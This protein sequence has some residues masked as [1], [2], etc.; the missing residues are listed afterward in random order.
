MFLFVGSLS[1]AISVAIF[2]LLV[3]VM[4]ALPADATAGPVCRAGGVAAR[5]VTAPV[6]F[7]GKRTRARR[8][9]RHT[10][11]GVFGGFFRSCFSCGC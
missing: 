4:T 9:A 5:V 3:I 11:G 2:M 1:R 7:V 6:R 8:D 10:R